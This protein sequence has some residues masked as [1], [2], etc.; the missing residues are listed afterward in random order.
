MTDISNV[1]DFASLMK[2][3][4]FSLPDMIFL[5]VSGPKV[6]FESCW[7]PLTANLCNN[8]VVNGRIAGRA[9]I[10]KREGGKCCNYISI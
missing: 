7:L 5:T 6:Q 8:H 1:Y 4:R 3:A 9:K 10:G 2:P